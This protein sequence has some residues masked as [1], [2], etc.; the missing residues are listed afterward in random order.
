MEKEKYWNEE[1][2][3]VLLPPYYIVIYIDDYNQ[4]HMAMIKDPL[5]L[6]FLQGRYI[7]EDAKLVE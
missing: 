7:V 2:E 5:Y 6:K 3:E 4:R 1:E